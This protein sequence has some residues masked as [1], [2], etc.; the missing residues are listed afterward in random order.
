MLCSI[1]RCIVTE[2]SIDTA[3]PALILWHVCS[4]QLFNMNTRTS[5]KM[6]NPRIIWPQRKTT[7]LPD[8]KRCNPQNRALWKYLIN[9]FL[10]FVNLA[11][12]CTR[13]LSTVNKRVCFLKTSASLQFS[14]LHFNIFSEKCNSSS[15]HLWGGER[16][17]EKERESDTVHV[18]INL[19][20]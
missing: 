1:R 12:I 13:T 3:G 18:W 7:G 19:P 2:T 16:E 14:N 4:S 20:L 17:R 5:F 6:F 15:V 9:V 10:I 8:I 11:T